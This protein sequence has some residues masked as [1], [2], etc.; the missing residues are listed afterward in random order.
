MAG[1]AGVPPAY[2]D[3]ESLRSIR[4]T[5]LSFSFSQSLLFNL[6][7]HDHLN[8]TFGAGNGTD[9]TALA[10]IEINSD[11]SRLLIP[12]NTKIR[13]EEAAGLTGFACSQAQ[14]ALSLLDG[15]LLR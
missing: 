11:L 6:F 4:S 10:I 2:K 14:A 7:V 12:R 8:R 9:A 5:P 15:L 3:L 13:A 1:S